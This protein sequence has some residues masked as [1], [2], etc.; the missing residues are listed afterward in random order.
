MESQKLQKATYIS[1]KNSKTEGSVSSDF[2]FYLKG[3]LITSS[4][5][6]A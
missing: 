1:I 5:A 6:L 3:L 4:M 2:N